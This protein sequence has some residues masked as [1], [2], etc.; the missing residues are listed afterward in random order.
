LINGELK[1]FMAMFTARM[2]FYAVI[3]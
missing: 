3:A 1:V 2:F